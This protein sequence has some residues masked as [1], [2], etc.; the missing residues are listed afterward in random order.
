MSAQWKPGYH[1]PAC[2]NPQHSSED[3]AKDQASQPGEPQEETL[4]SR[5][6]PPQEDDTARDSAKDQASQP[7]EP[8]EELFPREG[9]APHEGPF[10]CEGL[11]IGEISLSPGARLCPPR[12]APS[13]GIKPR[14]PRE[15]F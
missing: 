13:R 7:G 10:P 14:F 15:G 1:G 6:P 3:F 4:P 12:E 9:L 5:G 2:H 11:S 8:D